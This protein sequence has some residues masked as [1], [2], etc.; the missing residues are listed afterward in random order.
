MRQ[1]LT[2]IGSNKRVQKRCPVICNF[3]LVWLAKNKYNGVNVTI[4]KIA[5]IRTLTVCLWEI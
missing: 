3:G 5:F 2:L 4:K 1:S